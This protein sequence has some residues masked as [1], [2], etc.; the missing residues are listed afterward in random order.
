MSASPDENSTQWL[1]WI[2]GGLVALF[3]AITGRMHMSNEANHARAEAKMSAL[4]N[5]FKAND[6]N[7]WAEIKAVDRTNSDFREKILEHTVTKDDLKAME[8]R[9]INVFSGKF[10]HD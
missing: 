3:T 5:E 1:Q 4:R 7:L 2:I 10:G 8:L 9:L 6:D